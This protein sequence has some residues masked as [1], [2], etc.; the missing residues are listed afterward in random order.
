MPA[1]AAAPCGNHQAV[2]ARALKARVEALQLIEREAADRLKGLDTRPFAFL[3]AQA[4]AAAGLIGEAK[5]LADEDELARCPEPVPHVRRVCATAALALAGL[6]NA[7]AEGA[8]K[9]I[10]PQTYAQ[11]IA[12][13]EG[14]VGLRPLNTAWRAGE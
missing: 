5:A 1:Q 8:T 3:A 9:G 12:I 11:A 10:L 14:L 2:A 4:T 7:Q 13:C 6:L